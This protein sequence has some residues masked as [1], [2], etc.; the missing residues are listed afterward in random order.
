[1]NNMIEYEQKREKIIHINS[2][3]KPWWMISCKQKEDYEMIG[4]KRKLKAN[5]SNPLISNQNI[6]LLYY[7]CV[8]EMQPL[9]KK[10]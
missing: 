7:I 3:M 8:Y 4:K 9:H 2:I 6:Y 5:W 10:K 1:M